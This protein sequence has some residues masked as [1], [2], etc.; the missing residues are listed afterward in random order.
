MESWLMPLLAE[1]Y[2]AYGKHTFYRQWVRSISQ[3]LILKGDEPF[4]S[5]ILQGL[6][7]HLSSHSLWT[8]SPAHN[9]HLVSGVILSPENVAVLGPSW[10]P[11]LQRD[12]SPR[13]YESMTIC[14]TR[15]ITPQIPIDV[16]RH[17]FIAKEYLHDLQS[18]WNNQGRFHAELQSIQSRLIA[19]LPKPRKE[20]Q[21][22]VSH[23]FLSTLTPLGPFFL[24]RDQAPRHIRRTFIVSPLGTGVPSMLK[25][26]GL[27]AAS[28]YHR[29]LFVH[30]GLDPSQI[31]HIYFPDASWLISNNV[32][33]HHCQA[34]DTDEVIKIS[35]LP[36]REAKDFTRMENLYFLYAQAYHQAWEELSQMPAISTVPNTTADITP[37]IQKILSHPI[38]H[39]VAEN[40]QMT[41]KP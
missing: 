22:W 25:R 28:H 36:K 37:W 4:V 17:L 33:P 18:L 32:A 34:N 20:G 3:A 9:P 24:H 41:G 10:L 12:Q 6:V 27:Y 1:A 11:F 40:Q 13:C 21:T 35:D 30:C 31:D 39:S 5:A 16:S 26:V 15:S 23:A 7:K 8:F 14:P 38:L 29:V 2:T 19:Q